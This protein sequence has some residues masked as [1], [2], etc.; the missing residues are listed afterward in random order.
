[1]PL[2][3]F[4]PI[5]AMSDSNVATDA[6][7]GLLTDA[8]S[9]NS[10]TK[11]VPS[12]KKILKPWITPG[13][14]RCIRHRDQLHKRLKQTPNNNTLEICYK[15]YRNFCNKIL[16]KVKRQFDTQELDKA[17][18]NS[19]VLWEAIKR[20]TNTHKQQHA[21]TLLLSHSDT[22]SQSCNNLNKFF[23][24]IGKKL[25]DNIINDQTSPTLPCSHT[26]FSSSSFVLEHT[27]IDE[28]KSLIESLRSTAA[29]GWDGISPTVLKRY[30][31][32]LAPVLN[33]IFNLCFETAVFPSALKKAI[34][35]P[36][37]RVV[38]ETLLII[39]AP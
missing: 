1:M 3:D 10:S 8:I 19:K 37:L 21:S 14:L 9:E 5:Y 35:H 20:I 16:K 13:L 31:N 38:M 22:P 24:D 18:N 27:D 25:A 33:H 30:C 15:R 11:K 17:G 7:I 34:I 28:V 36:S 2:L 29:T 39:I 12:N 26:N 4:T 23:A 6:L 32:V